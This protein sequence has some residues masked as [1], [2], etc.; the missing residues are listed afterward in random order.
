MRPLLEG[1]AERAGAVPAAAPPPGPDACGPAT[2]SEVGAMSLRR[3]CDVC[4]E[5]ADPRDL[6]PCSLCGHVFH[7]PRTGGA[8]TCGVVAPNPYSEQGC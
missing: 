1:S 6:L 7:V 3:R 5:S 4:G 2:V 8:P